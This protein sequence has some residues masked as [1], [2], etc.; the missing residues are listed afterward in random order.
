MNTTK[1]IRPVVV[2]IFVVLGILILVV[3][4]FTLGAEKETFVKLTPINAVFDDVGGL[5]VGGNIRFSGVKV[6]TVKKMSFYGNSQVLVTMNIE[7]A[8]I[9]HIRKDAFAKIGSDGLIG[10]KIIIIYGG[11]AQTPQVVKDDYLKVENALSTEDMLATLQQNNKNILEITKDFKNISRKID[12]GKGTLAM[13]LNDATIAQSLGASA[14]TLHETM[15][16]LKTVSEGSKDVMA[17]LQAFSERINKKGNSIHDLARDTVVYGSIKATFAQLNIASNFLT[18]FTAN[19]KT[20]SDKLNQKDN[21]VG[22]LLN[23]SEMAASLKT[24][25]KNLETGSK[26]LDE[27]LEALQHNFLLRRF[28]KKKAKAED[29]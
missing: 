10:N 29:K 20:V 9:E 14:N 18:K 26:K 19:L 12:N 2:G 11:K 24:T 5:Q 17:N 4:I 6:G 1:N 7:Q 23:D 15:V 8:I 28:F 25:L 13:L 22:V 3:T 21:S 16:N 27:D